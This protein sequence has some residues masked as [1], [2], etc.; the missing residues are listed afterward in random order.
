MRDADGPRPPTTPTRSYCPPPQRHAPPPRGRSP[1]TPSTVPHSQ[2]RSCFF[3]LLVAT[4]PAAR[5]DGA[6]VPS[7][8]C[9]TRRTTSAA[10]AP[11]PRRERFSVG[12]ER[13][14][15]QTPD[16]AADRPARWERR[17]GPC[18][19]ARGC[20]DRAD[21]RPPPR[22]IR[23]RPDHL[24]RPRTHHRRRQLPN[25]PT[26][27]RQLPLTPTSANV[28]TPTPDPKHPGPIGLAEPRPGLSL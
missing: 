1:T 25:P 26:N 5:R 28:T 21:D 4:V 15:Q 13:V 18:S 12:L 14:A 8:I 20:L 24:R 27:P 9:W 2:R 23:H 19:G 10:P 11:R 7:S 16:R 22:P 3:I 6:L 17:G